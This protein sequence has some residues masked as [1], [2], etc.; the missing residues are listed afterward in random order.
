MDNAEGRAH[1]SSNAAPL[2]RALPD[3]A[4]KRQL[5]SELAALIQLDAA[6]LGSLW[7]SQAEK[8]LARSAPRSTLPIAGK[9]SEQALTDDDLSS[10]SADI[11]LSTTQYPQFKTAQRA[12]SPWKKD[13]NGKWRKDDSPPP[14]MG[15]RSLPASRAD[16]ACRL[17]LGNMALWDSMTGEDHAMLCGLPSPHGGL[18]AWLECQFHDH[19]PLAW[20]TL[21]VDMQDQT[22]ATLACKLMAT[23]LSV[24]PTTDT[25]VTPEEAKL[26][27]R[28]LLN[29]MLI[30]RLKLLQTEALTE[31][32]KQQDPMA[33]ERWRS[34]D[35]RR[36][37]L[38]ASGV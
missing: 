8:A 25:S 29:L 31:V 22:F 34:L 16:H 4:L 6:E 17:V 26:E 33:L 2:W 5:L 14:S 27:L 30:D 38:M 32:E 21:Q 3:G 35:K 37:E 7:Q 9:R 1:M 13:V 18:F 12:P 10:L 15:P 28:Q 20:R 24:D 23:H 19:G 36:K 11:Y